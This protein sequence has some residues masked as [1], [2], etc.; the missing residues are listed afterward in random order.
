MVHQ[1]SSL[2]VKQHVLALPPG[3]LSPRPFARG[4]NIRSLV[5][6]DA[7]GPVDETKQTEDQQEVG[8]EENPQVTDRRTEFFWNREKEL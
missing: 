6:A 7:V 3:S 4:E 8:Q 2:P 5:D 1:M